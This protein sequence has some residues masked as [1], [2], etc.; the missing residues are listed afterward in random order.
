MRVNCHTADWHELLSGRIK[1]D[2]NGR[3]CAC[4]VREVALAQSIGRE[5]ESSHD[6]ADK[7]R[8]TQNMLNPHEG[9]WNQT[10]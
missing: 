9:V 2:D 10:V 3:A 8:L 5:K 7:D 4:M 6:D 1:D